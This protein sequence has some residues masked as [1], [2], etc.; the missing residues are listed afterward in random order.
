[1]SYLL[2]YWFKLA[3]GKWGKIRKDDHRQIV[4]EYWCFIEEEWAIMTHEGKYYWIKIIWGKKIVFKV[5]IYRGKKKL[6]NWIFLF[7]V[8]CCM[9]KSKILKFTNLIEQ[10][11][12]TS[13]NNTYD[14][15]MN[16]NLWILSRKKGSPKWKR[17]KKWIER[18]RFVERLPAD[19]AVSRRGTMGPLII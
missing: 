9:L 4:A 16:Q 15:N 10:T 5:G 14:A 2:L 12:F 6:K 17:R 13:V 1:M 11:K 3:N 19:W 8:F 18:G 7:S